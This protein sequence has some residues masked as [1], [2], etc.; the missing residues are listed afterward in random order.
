MTKKINLEPLKGVLGC[1]VFYYSRHCAEGGFSHLF[2]PVYLFDSKTCTW[3][4]GHGH[5]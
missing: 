1:S 2:N 4:R 3:E 5:H